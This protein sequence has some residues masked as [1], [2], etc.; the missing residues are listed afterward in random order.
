MTIYSKYKHIYIYVHIIF[1]YIYFQYLFICLFVFQDSSDSFGVFLLYIQVVI[2]CCSLCSACFFLGVSSQIG[3]V[4][5]F[6]GVS[7][8]EAGR[9]W[10]S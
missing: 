9:F 8:G 2:K 7:A 5:A 6:F 1:I 10:R 3:G 4:G